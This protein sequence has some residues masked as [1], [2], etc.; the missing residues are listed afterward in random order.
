MR[1]WLS[2]RQFQRLLLVKGT[3]EETRPRS[4]VQLPSEGTGA[5]T[6]LPFLFCGEAS[7]LGFRPQ[8]K[9]LCS[10][11]VGLHKQNGFQ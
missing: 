11:P 4:S 8:T 2:E 7:K 1:I 9:A 3:L 6:P 5:L 10:T